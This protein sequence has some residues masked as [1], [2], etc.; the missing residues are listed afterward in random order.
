MKEGEKKIIS[1]RSIQRITHYSQLSTM[2]HC[3]LQN[4]TTLREKKKSLGRVYAC[5]NFEIRNQSLQ[6][7]FRYPEYPSNSSN[8][9]LLYN[10]KYLISPGHKASNIRSKKQTL[11]KG[12]N[13]NYE[14]QKEKVIKR[15]LGSLTYNRREKK[16]ALQPFLMAFKFKGSKCVAGL[17]RLWRHLDVLISI[18][19]IIWTKWRIFKL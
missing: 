8:H 18:I 13:K 4:Y 7:F 14:R 3:F 12:N 17:V 2:P 10:W 16:V 5:N 15:G 9:F 19:T 6:I 11:K 1:L